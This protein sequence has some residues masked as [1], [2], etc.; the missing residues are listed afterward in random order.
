MLLRIHS[1]RNVIVMIFRFLKSV[2]ALV[3]RPKKENFP[4]CRIPCY[5]RTKSELEIGN[6][7]GQLRRITRLPMEW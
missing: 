4:H 2:W 6:Q 7:S 5:D 3:F 1:W